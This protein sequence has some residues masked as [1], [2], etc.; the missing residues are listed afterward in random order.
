MRRAFDF[1][2]DG[3]TPIVSTTPI[4]AK[5]AGR[6][7]ALTDRESL[8]LVL[9]ALGT[10]GRTR[11]VKAANAEVDGVSMAVVVIEHA[12]FGAE[13]EQIIALADVVEGAAVKE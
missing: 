11:G 5:K 10:L 1:L 3:L 13:Q 9:G 2:P 12:R 7:R 6:S 4:Q 8:S